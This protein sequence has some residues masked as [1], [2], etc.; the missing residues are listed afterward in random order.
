MLSHTGADNGMLIG[1]FL[2]LRNPLLF[3]RLLELLQYLLS[4]LIKRYQCLQS[5][6]AMYIV[7]IER[8]FTHC[9]FCRF[10]FFRNDTEIKNP[11][12]ICRLRISTGEFD[13]SARDSVF[14]HQCWI[15]ISHKR[16]SHSRCNT[17]FS[18]SLR[19]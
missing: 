19:Q 2:Y 11:E 17:S 13:R 10:K 15:F 16:I 9:P 18:H 3:F 6:A 12:E 1:K 5:K 7:I 4:P 8:I 14:I